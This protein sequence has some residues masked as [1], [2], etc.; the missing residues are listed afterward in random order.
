[1]EVEKNGH[2]YAEIAYQNTVFI[3][4]KRKSSIIENAKDVHAY[5]DKNGEVVI[6]KL[7]L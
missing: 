1:M 5:I 7:R 6:D 2:I 3:V 4:W